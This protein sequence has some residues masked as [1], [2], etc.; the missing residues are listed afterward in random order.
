MRTDPRYSRVKAMITDEAV[1]RDAFGLLRLCKGCQ[2]NV[3][4]AGGFLRL[5]A[6]RLY[7]IA[8][9]H[10]DRRDA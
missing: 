1:P 8:R 5:L 2:R 3:Y 6:D 9:Y 4:F 7:Q 10:P